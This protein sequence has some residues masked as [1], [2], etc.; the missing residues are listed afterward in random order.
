ME[1]LGGM[2]SLS[3]Q[4]PISKTQ[5]RFI[6]ESAQMIADATIEHDLQR[7][8]C[9]ALEA[10]D[11]KLATFQSALKVVQNFNSLVEFNKVQPKR[12]PTNSELETIL[13]FARDECSIEILPVSPFSP[14]VYGEV[15]F[16][17]IRRMCNQI[18]TC[19][20][21]SFVDIGAG[22][23]QAVLQVAGTLKLEH[24]MGLEIRDDLYEVSLKFGQNFRRHMEWFGKLH[25]PFEFL[26]GDVTSG[27][28][29][30]R[31]FRSTVYFI[32]NYEFDAV[33]NNYIMDN[34]MECRDGTVAYTT[35][36][37]VR[38]R[39]YRSVK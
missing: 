15:S 26:R 12:F 1:S 37:F 28:L 16:D 14:H 10:A 20:G 32:N 2:D 38:D 19:S 33:T 31:I 9:L 21:S 6:L 30:D 35:K 11:G 22:I 34:L 25:S 17:L 8:L 39:S 3:F 7:G 4:W 36:R 29:R 5:E 27:D 24:C 13:Q 18:S 23:G